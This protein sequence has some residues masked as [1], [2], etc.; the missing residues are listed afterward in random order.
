MFDSRFLL[1]ADMPRSTGESFSD[2]IDRLL[3]REKVDL[4]DYFG[5]IEDDDLLKGLEEDSKKIR[6]LSKV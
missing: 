6:E 4:A 3:R 1:D 5:V 2:A